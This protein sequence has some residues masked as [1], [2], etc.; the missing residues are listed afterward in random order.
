M[1][2]R[3]QIFE[4]LCARRDMYLSQTTDKELKEDDISVKINA[5]VIRALSWVLNEPDNGYKEI[6]GDLFR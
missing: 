1:K 6:K 5:E 4:E 2:R 3:K